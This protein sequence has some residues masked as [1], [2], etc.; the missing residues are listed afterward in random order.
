VLYCTFNYVAE[1]KPKAKVDEYRVAKII[2]RRVRVLCW[3]LTGVAN[4]KTKA[5]HVK[6][7]WAPRCNKYIFMSS[8]FDP[9]LPAVGLENVQE[10][11]GLLW[12]KTRA[13]FAYVYKHYY[14]KYD[15]FMKADDDTFVIVEN[16]RFM[17]MPFEPTEPIWFG[18]N[19]KLEGD[20]T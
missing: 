12:G 18:A 11:H 9:D 17:L 20:K 19:F 7:T 2:K 4:H 13:A 14:N 1:P 15:W 8:V 5:R 6:E 16:L 10:G 3:I